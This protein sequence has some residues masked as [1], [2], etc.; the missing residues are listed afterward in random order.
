[1]KNHNEVK[2]KGEVPIKSPE[3]IEANAGMPNACRPTDP[4]CSNNEPVKAT[5]L[6]V[7]S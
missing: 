5:A 1:M 4:C 7:I 2:E 3:Q 6:K